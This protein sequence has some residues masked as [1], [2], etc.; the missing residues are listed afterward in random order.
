MLLVTL[1]VRPDGLAE[2]RA[3]ETRAAV[4]MGKYGGR[5]VVT[6]VLDPSEGETLITE[7]H[8]VTFPDSEAFARYR[9]DAELR[10][11]LPVRD[12]VV[13]RTSIRVG[14]MGP[15]YGS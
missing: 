1:D 9:N 8:I 5:N 6:M 2:F 10:A 4:I 15:R 14:R 13:A 11:L 12:R 3:Y 7:V